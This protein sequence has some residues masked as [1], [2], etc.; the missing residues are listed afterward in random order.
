MKESNSLSVSQMAYLKSLGVD[1]SSASMIWIHVGG[2]LDTEYY[3]LRE[4]A[5]L[6]NPPHGS[7]LAFSCTDILRILGTIQ[8]NSITGGYKV[9]VK[10]QVWDHALPYP[11]ATD[12]SIIGAA[13]KLLCKLS[14]GR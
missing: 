9:T 8:L 4:R 6:D 2:N 5:E 11:S 1:D 13:Y 7:I 10:P 12:E 3:Y 14:R